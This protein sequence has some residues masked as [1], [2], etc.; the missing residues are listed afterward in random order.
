MAL[1]GCQ[2]NE[3]VSD[4]APAMQTITLSCNIADNPATKVNVPATGT[5][6][7]QPTWQEGDVIAVVGS[8][9]KLYSFT[10]D[11]SSLSA[12]GKSA[13]FTGSIPG[14]LTV[15]GAIYPSFSGATAVSDTPA[16]FASAVMDQTY[17][18]NA[19]DKN[20]FILMGGEDSGVMRFAHA[21]TSF[22]LHLKGTATIGK[23]EICGTDGDDNDVAEAC[24]NCGSGVA[25]DENTSKIFAISTCYHFLKDEK[26]KFKFYDTSDNLLVT[27]TKTIKDGENEYS[28]ILDLTTELTIDAEGENIPEYLCF[29]AK[30][31]GCQITL[32]GNNSYD[33]GNTFQYSTD[34]DS[35]SDVTLGTAFPEAA[36]SDGGKVY[37]KAT[38]DRTTAPVISG[39]KWLVISATENFAVSGSLMYLVDSEG[40]DSYATMND[41]EFVGL[42]MQCGKLVDASGLTLPSQTSEGC[43]YGMFGYATNLTA[44]PE[45]PA[46]N[47]ATACYMMMFAACTSLTTAPELPA[48]N[49]ATTCYYQMFDGCTALTAAPT[50]PAT[51]LAYNCYYGMFDGCTSLTAAPTL[52]ATT[53]A[54]SCYYYMFSGCT[55]LTAAPALPATTLAYKCYESMFDGCTALTQ[56]PELT[57]ET[58]TQY[59]YGYMFHGCTSLT[60]APAL[61]ATTLADYCYE[62][63]FEGCTSLTAAPTLSAPTLAKGCYESMFEGCTSLTAAPALSATTLAQDC[64]WRMFYGCTSLAQAPALSATTLAQSCY[65]AMFFGCTSLT[66]APALPATTLVKYCYYNMFEDCSSL[67][68]ATSQATDGFDSQDCLTDW[69]TGTAASGTLTVAA[70]T[71][72]N[73]ASHVPAGWTIEDP[74]AP[75]T[76]G[77]AKAT[78]NS[79]EYDIPW[80]QLWENGPKFAKYNYDSDPTKMSETNLG[81]TMYWSSTFTE[82]G[83]NWTI[84]TYDTSGEGEYNMYNLCNNMNTSADP[85]VG[86]YVKCTFEEKGGVYGM[87][88]TGVQEGYTE[89]SLF[90]P[91]NSSSQYYGN[92]NVWSG[93]NNDYHYC[94][95]VSYYSGYPWQAFEWNPRSNTSSDKY[96][97]IPVLK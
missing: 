94:L 47:L 25:L 63:M 85:A 70:G 24:L 72:S 26:L 35:W 22:I 5:G 69:L 54:E 56:A 75:A 7:I 78:I 57:A 84:G 61:S 34:G 30:A 1:A 90:I 65:N 18:E 38:S 52:P 21:F 88:F 80:V 82:W 41:Y 40:G 14:N 92:F 8:D 96:Y 19:F 36:L 3:I 79:T 12:D 59:C 23:I 29:T 81:T 53:L 27:K 95:Y 58:L 39:Q 62:N 71:S 93:S 91:T 17:T 28:G 64:Y 20:T 44:A 10:M 9:N 6:N 50:L 87:T 45:L 66:E 46:E 33:P 48:E 67:N 74:S 76:T 49:L 86:T 68:A 2:K 60:A 37:V 4:E 55:S 11:D 97:V 32:S 77:T 13:S 16:S 43:Y 51:T 42:F 15:I 89:N 31:D 73:W 83:D